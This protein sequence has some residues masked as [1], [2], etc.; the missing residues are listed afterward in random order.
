MPTNSSNGQNDTLPVQFA[1]IVGDDG[2]A[3]WE[4]P[5]HAPG[6][7]GRLPFT[8]EMLVER[9]SGDIFG[10]SQNA[11]MGWQPSELLRKQFPGPEHHRRPARTRRIADCARFSHRPLGAQRTRSERGRR[12]EITEVGTFRSVLFRSMRRPDAGYAGDVRQP[13]LPQRRRAGDAQAGEVSSHRP[14]RDGRGHVRQGTPRHDDGAGRPEKTC[15][16]S[17]CRAA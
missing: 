17:P 1:D 15:R 9:P 13:A 3:G 8:A 6:P 10:F 12:A 2:V 7:E 4:T 14:R 11:G 5:T 16:S